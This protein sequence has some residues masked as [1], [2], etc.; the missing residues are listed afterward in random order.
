MKGANII[1]RALWFLFFLFYFLPDTHAGESTA[2]QHTKRP[3]INTIAE[4]Q[5]QENPLE[6]ATGVYRIVLTPQTPTGGGFFCSYA[7]KVF[8]ENR[9]ILSKTVGDVKGE[10]CSG[11][12]SL[13]DIT[14]EDTRY[15]L[16][17]SWSGGAHCCFTLQPIVYRD[18][19]VKIF[20]EVFLGNTGDILEAKNFF[21]YNGK[22]Y[23]ASDDDRFQYYHLS[24][25]DSSL[26]FFPIF[27]SFDFKEGKM[28]RVDSRFRSCY[29]KL[30]SGTAKQAARLKKSPALLKQ[31]SAHLAWFPLIVSKAVYALLAGGEQ[32]QVWSDFAGD[33]DY[34]ARKSADLHSLCNNCTADSLAKEIKELMAGQLQEL[35][36]SKDDN[37]TAEA[38]E[39]LCT[40]VDLLRQNRPDSGRKE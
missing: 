39:E 28:E 2:L 7:I 1:I 10:D 40:A 9:E 35:P 36:L 34:F 5:R 3:M 26:L 31:P 38:P 23:M 29:E 37:A 27:Y 19:A 22:V 4:S 15:Y 24:F 30:L 25:A 17:V 12:I 14:Y 21:V 33:F 32:N 20:D 8:K 18:G 13:Y 11:L 16:A 6:V